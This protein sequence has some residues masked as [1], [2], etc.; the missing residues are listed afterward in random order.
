[1]KSV[2]CW[3]DLEQ[4]GIDLLTGEACGYM[5]RFLCDVTA[6]GKAAIE[7]CL[8]CSLTLHEN[9]NSGSEHDPHIGSIMLS[10][11]MFAP[12]AAFCLLE[13]GFIEVWLMKT[14]AAFGIAQDDLPEDVQRWKQ[15]HQNDV[16]HILRSKAPARNQ[17]QMTGRTV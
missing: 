13:A 10:Q 6:N 15:F 5:Y 2:T 17:H 3:R 1:M 9:W 7:K 16:C 12:L 14:G 4:F 8:D 11:E